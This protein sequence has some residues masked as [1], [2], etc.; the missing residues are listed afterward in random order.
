MS[1]ILTMPVHENLTRDHDTVGVGGE[2]LSASL[3][4]RIPFFVER[5]QLYYWTREWRE[6]EA[7]ALRDLGEGRFRTFSDGTSAAQW[8]LS[9]DEE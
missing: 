7:E 9:D 5:S 8:L 2:T 4:R 3:R 1:D 6:G